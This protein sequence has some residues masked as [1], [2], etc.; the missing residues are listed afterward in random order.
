[1]PVS[2][3]CHDDEA[4]LVKCLMQGLTRNTRSELTFFLLPSLP[5]VLIHLQEDKHE[6]GYLKSSSLAAFSLLLTAGVEGFEMWLGF[7]L[8]LNFQISQLPLPHQ[9]EN[10]IYQNFNFP[11]M[12][13]SLSGIMCSWAFSLD[14]RFVLPLP[15]WISL[16]VIQLT[17]S[18]DSV[19]IIL[20]HLFILLP[21]FHALFIAW[22]LLKTRDHKNHHFKI[23]ILNFKWI[24]FCKL[25]LTTQHLNSMGKQF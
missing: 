11:R 25:L 22:N 16:S 5:L 2:Y 4:I 23:R 1:M 24:F 18:L 7:E 14:L 15:F 10:L 17:S 8:S 6:D 3:G 20:H 9:Q 19:S 12:T 21:L 13:L